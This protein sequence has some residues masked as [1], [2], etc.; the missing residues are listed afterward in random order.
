MEIYDYKTINGKN[1][2]LD[3]LKQLQD[4]ERLKILEIRKSIEHNGIYAFEDLNTRQLVG[5]LWEIKVSKIR[6]MYVIVDDQAVYFLN[7]CRKQKGK[8]EK[9]E[10]QKAI[11]RAKR[12]GLL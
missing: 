7:V 2:I 4:R 10:L 5:K 11:N 9:Q 3:Y 6:L 12:E 1:V 8:A